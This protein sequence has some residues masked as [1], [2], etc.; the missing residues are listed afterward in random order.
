MTISRGCAAFLA[1]LFAA[2]LLFAQDQQWKQLSAQA[3]D[4][5]HQGKYAEALPI[6]AV[7]TVHANPRLYGGLLVH[8][9]VVVVAIALATTGGYTTK[10]EVRFDRGRSKWCRH[11]R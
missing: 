5:E 10:R 6:A 3:R 1:L 2:S 4:L 9:G 8:A 7:R 11:A